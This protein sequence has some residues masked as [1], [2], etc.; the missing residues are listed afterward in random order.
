MKKELVAAI[1]FFGGLWGICEAVVGGA[2]YGSHMAHASVIL[3]VCGLVVLTFA[4]VYLP[5]KGTATA[6]AACAML[7]KFLNE[8]FFACHLVGILLTGLC[9][10]LAFAGLKIKNRAVAAAATVYASYALFALLMTYVVRYEHWVEAGFVRVLGHV[11]VSGTMAAAVCALLVPLSF[12]LA[13]RLGRS[14]AMP[15]ESRPRL[16]RGA[17]S[18]ATAGLWVFGLAVYFLA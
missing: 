6:I 7:Y 17:V 11:A 4:R 13:A 16:V 5:Q 18:L 3:T 9:Y 2:L 15:F 10:D 8:P 12:R 1:F 14:P